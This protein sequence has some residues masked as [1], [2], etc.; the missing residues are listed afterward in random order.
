M[1][2]HYEE[3]PSRPDYDGYLTLSEA[4]E[5]YRNGGGQPLYV[6]L[7]RLNLNMVNGNDFPK[8]QG[9]SEP[10]NLLRKGNVSDGLIYGTI[11]LTLDKAQSFF[12]TSDNYGFEM[13]RGRP[14]RN[15]L[16]IIGEKV[17]GEGAPFDIIFYGKGRIGV[18]F[19]PQFPIG[20]KF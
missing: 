6:D 12:S 20:P 19:V 5:W 1:T 8:G 11:T 14:I 9:S 10:I 2:S 7:G 17:A 18:P 16:T 3:L 13:H 15:I 4:N